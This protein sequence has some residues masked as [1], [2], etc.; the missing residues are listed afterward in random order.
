MDITS[1]EPLRDPHEP[2]LP[3][4]VKPE[5]VAHV[6]DTPPQKLDEQLA[7]AE[8]PNADSKPEAEAPQS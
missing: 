5:E 6:E 3:E 8:A 7:E 4:G 2:V 1:N